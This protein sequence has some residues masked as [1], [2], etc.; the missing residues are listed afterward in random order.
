M[1]IKKI[2]NFLKQKKLFFTISLFFILTAVFLYPIFLGKIALPLDLLVN[3]KS[4]WQLYF[5][6]PIKNPFLLDSVIQIFPWKSLVADLIKKGVFPLWNPFSGTGMPFFANMK[7]SLLYPLTWLLLLGKQTGW[8]LL[9]FLQ[10]FLSFIFFYVL[11]K[12]LN[13]K[14]NVAFFSSIAFSLNSL[15]IGFLEFGHEGHV[16]MFFPLMLA[17]ILKS[18]KKPSK[19]NLIILT[20]TTSLSALAGQFQHFL[21]GFVLTFI[22]NLYLLFKKSSFITLKKLT[23]KNLLK[24][25]KSFF[26][27]EFLKNLKVSLALL[28]GLGISLAQVLPTLQMLYLSQRSGLDFNIFS[29][30]LLKPVQ[31]LRFFAP[32]Y[33]GHP[34]SRN[35]WGFTGY[36]EQA[37]YFGVIPLFFSLIAFFFY[38][39]NKIINFFKSAFLISILL[40][41][42]PFAYII[43]FLKI[44]VLS[45]NPGQRILVIAPLCAS[46]LAGFGLKYFLNNLKQKKVKLSLILYLLIYF[47]IFFITFSLKKANPELN[48][49]LSVALRNLIFPIG[50]TFLFVTSVFLFLLFK[51]FF[52]N[53]NL[54]VF[55]KKIE[56]NLKKSYLVFGFTIL[57]FLDLFRFGHK[58]LPFTP[59]DYFYPQAAVLNFLQEKSKNLKRFYGPIEPELPAYLQIYSLETYNPLYPKNYAEFISFFNNTKELDRNRVLVDPLS[60]DIKRLFDL[61]ST[62]VFVIRKDYFGADW[63]FPVE[64]YEKSFQKIWENDDFIVFENL[65]ALP[66]F[67]LFYNFKIIKEKEDVLTVLKKE[68]KSF[69]FKNTLILE[70]DLNLKLEKGTGSAKLLQNNVNNL[71]FKVKT[72]KKALLLLTDNYYPGWLAKINNKPAEIY[73]TNFTFRS[74]LVP[75]GESVVEFSYQ[76]QVLYIG[77]LIA[78]LSL[79]VS[80][81]LL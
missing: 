60:K 79:L 25:V 11:G 55:N 35:M 68:D 56:L 61:S 28:L 54:I 70:K 26:K 24:T 29:N 32:D 49:N 76:P 27:K 30:D 64:K 62:S 7:T 78:L 66:R 58:F 9:L 1:K 81:I 73:K 37:A 38:K 77:V 21:Y 47:I 74:V 17:F 71:S 43:Y 23:L 57:L 48:Q 5:T 19:K 53:K 2:N 4:P 45:T 44:P 15:M 12:E 46:L 20:L 13:F 75:Q 36:I 8:Q 10:I 3:T 80:I 67:S 33:F 40:A 34:A 65:D 50:L 16:I 18:Y 39:K 42:E 72:N 52:K 63:S 22:F 59:K 14:N 31:L 69:D 6:S 51:K 41:L